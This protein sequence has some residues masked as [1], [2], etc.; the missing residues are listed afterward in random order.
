MMSIGSFHSA[1]GSARLWRVFASTQD[2]VNAALMLY[3]KW[4]PAE[5]LC[6]P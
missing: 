2:L 3:R 6:E 4:S 5:T 1:D